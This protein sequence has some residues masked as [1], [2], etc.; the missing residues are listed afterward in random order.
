MD[1]EPDIHN[2]NF[3]CKSCESRYKDMYAYRQHLRFVHY[4]V[5][6]RIPRWKAPRND[7]VPDPNDPN[8]YCRACDHTY[9]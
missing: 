5:L 4:M 2:P 6:K 8:L 9:A 7:I 3:Y 1:E